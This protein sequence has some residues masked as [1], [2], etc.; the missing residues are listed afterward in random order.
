MTGKVNITDIT[1]TA[2][3]ER[4][5]SFSS[6]AASTSGVRKTAAVVMATLNLGDWGR[7]VMNSITSSR[8]NASRE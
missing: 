1:G 2:D 4:R 7:R 6:G 8:S 5:A 3:G